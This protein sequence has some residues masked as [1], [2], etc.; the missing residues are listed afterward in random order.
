MLGRASDATPADALANSSEKF[1][2][3][4]P[5]R[6]AEANVEAHAVGTWALKGSTAV[7]ADVLVAG[8]DVAACREVERTVRQATRQSSADDGWK[9][10]VLPSPE[11]RDRWTLGIKAPD[12]WRITSFEATNA[13]LPARVTET[14]EHLLPKRSE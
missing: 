1:T 9:V 13:E 11:R 4:F 6:R 7:A 2:R 8:L 3:S 14:L 10:S 12:G 5:Q